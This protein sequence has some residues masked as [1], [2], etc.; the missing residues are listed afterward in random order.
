MDITLRRCWLRI[1][2]SRKCLYKKGVP[3]IRD[4]QEGEGPAVRAGVGACAPAGVEPTPR[5]LVPGASPARQDA[6]NL[7]GPGLA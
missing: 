6:R 2:Q 5:L 7:R 1:D 4:A 3:F